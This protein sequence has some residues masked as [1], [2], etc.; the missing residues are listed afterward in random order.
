HNDAISNAVG[1]NTF[2]I[3]VALGFPLF[4]YGI[5]EGTIPMPEHDSVLG[6]RIALVVV[7]TVILGTFLIPKRVQFWQAIVLAILYIAWT[8]FIIST[9]V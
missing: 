8:V 7:T 4:L 6:L 3:C 2:D 5:T 9:E 1:S